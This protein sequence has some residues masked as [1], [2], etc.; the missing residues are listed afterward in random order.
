[1][2]ECDHGKWKRVINPTLGFISIKTAYATIKVIEVMHALRKGAYFY[3]WRS[4]DN[5]VFQANICCLS[6]SESLL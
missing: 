2:I 6:V 3:E 5:A 4:P 1:M